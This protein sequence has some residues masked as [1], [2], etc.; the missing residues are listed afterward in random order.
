L[1]SQIHLAS[2]ITPSD[3]SRREREHCRQQTADSRQQ[4]ADSRQQTADSRQQTADSRQQTET[5]TG[6][7]P[8]HLLVPQYTS[9]SAYSSRE[10]DIDREMSEFQ[11]KEAVPTAA[12]AMEGPP[13]PPL[14]PPA[15]VPTYA[16]L[17]LIPT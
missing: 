16:H 15:K 13:L 12:A 3:S 14:P 7:Y 11:Q 10:R 4:T 8:G 1:L 2:E 5:E 17:L 9:V 6:Q